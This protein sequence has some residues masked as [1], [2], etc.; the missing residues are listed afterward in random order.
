MLLNFKFFL[1]AVFTIFIS[2]TAYA[3]QND[4]AVYVNSQEN[5]FIVYRFESGQY[6]VEK[7]L[8]AQPNGFQDLNWQKRF[9]LELSAQSFLNKNLNGYAKKNITVADLLQKNNIETFREDYLT[10]VKDQVLWKHTQEW[11]WDWEI[12]YGEWV[13]QNITIDFFQKYNIPTDC[14]DLAYIARWIFSRI[15]NKC[16]R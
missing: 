12:K 6:V 1:Y 9:T 7:Y 11:S 13:T 8:Q 16:V 15:I 3:S 4:E 2:I 14:A 10:E 5:S